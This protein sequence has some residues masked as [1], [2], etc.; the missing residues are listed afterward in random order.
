MNTVHQEEERLRSML[1]PFEHLESVTL[2]ERRS[3]RRRLVVCGAIATAAVLTGVSLAG[4]L[5]P[6]RGI[7]AADHPQKPND[8]LGPDVTAQLRLDSPP[9]GGID[10]IGGRLTASGRF[11]GTLPSGR[12]VYVVPTTK[13]RLCVV[14]AGL[15]ESCGNPLT[16]QEPVTFTTVFQHP[17]DP[18]YAYGVAR[19]GVSTL[20]FTVNGEHVT[21]PVQHN[22]FVYETA[23]GDS[24]RGFGDVRATLAN[25]RVEPVG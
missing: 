25:G 21:V 24:P 19:D 6:L 20:S 15:V 8:V 3:R 4:S 22:F 12:K 18:T 5:N 23:P 9:G 1:A 10:Q 14:V 7:G 2:S 17:G 13:G 16:Q 11:I